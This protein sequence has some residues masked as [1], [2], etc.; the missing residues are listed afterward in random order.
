MIK[1]SFLSLVASMA[2]PALSAL[3]QDEE[4][5]RDD[6]TTSCISVRG[7]RSTDIIDDR[8]ILFYMRGDVV[9]H[10]ILSRRCPGLAREDRFSYRS[11]SSRL[12]DI[13]SINVL[14]RDARGMRPGA[15]CGLGKFFKITREDAKALKEGPTEDPAPK[16]LPMPE[17][18]EVG[19]EEESAGR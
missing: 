3:A 15:A 1:I 16:P 14:Y 9:Y 4:P 13:D 6:S 17:P 5:E 19:S 11:T 7:I 10:N 18:E 2:M 8:N 12:C